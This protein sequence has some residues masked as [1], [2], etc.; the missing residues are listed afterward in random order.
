MPLSRIAG[1]FCLYVLFA[2]IVTFGFFSVAY[3]AGDAADKQ[4]LPFEIRCP[5][6]QKYNPEHDKDPKKPKCIKGENKHLCTCKDITAGDVAVEGICYQAG[7]CTGEIC[8]GSKCRKTEPGQVNAPSE[9]PDT[10]APPPI[11]DTGGLGQP[12]PP[13]TTGGSPGGLGAPPSTGPDNSATNDPNS[14]TPATEPKSIWD[15]AL[16]NFRETGAT[17]LEAGGPQ[18]NSPAAEFNNAFNQIGS[19]PT[20]TNSAQPYNPDGSPNQNYYSGQSSATG[21]NAPSQ[22][23]ES[24]GGSWWDTA[25]QWGSSAWD[26]TKSTVS[27]WF[28]PESVGEPSP[29]LSDTGDVSG[30]APT[31][32]EVDS[33]FNGLEGT[34]PAGSESTPDPNFNG[35]EGAEPVDSQSWWDKYVATPFKDALQSGADFGQKMA[36][37]AFQGGE[38]GGTPTETGTPSDAYNPEP[39]FS[40]EGNV[41][42]KE[43]NAAADAQIEKVAAEYQAAGDL[44][45][46]KYNLHQAENKAIDAANRQTADQLTLE[47]RKEVLDKADAADKAAMEK[48]GGKLVENPPTPDCNEENGCTSYSKQFP[49]EKAK[50]AYE[51]RGTHKALNEAY[52][53]YETARNNY[54][55]SVQNAVDAEKE[56]QQT[57]TDA[58]DAQAAYN[59]ARKDNGYYDYTVPKS[60]T[61]TNPELGKN[62]P[63]AASPDTEEVTFKANSYEQAQQQLQGYIKA[64]QANVLREA[65]I[66]A[67]NQALQDIRNGSGNPSDIPVLQKENADLA[68]ANQLTAQRL[69]DF[70]NGNLD[71]ELTK[72]A[73]PNSPFLDAIKESG[74]DR[75][76]WGSVVQNWKDGNYGTAIKE[77]FENVVGGTLGHIEERFATAFGAPQNP[78]EGVFDPVGAKSDRIAAVLET[79]L[80][81][82]LPAYDLGRAGV[83][84]GRE[85]L[86][87]LSEVTNLGRAGAIGEVS[88]VTGWSRAGAAVDARA[89]EGSVLEGTVTSRFA[90]ESGTPQWTA[91]AGNTGALAAER[92]ALTTTSDGFTS[93]TGQ[94]RATLGSGGELAAAERSAVGDVNTVL[95]EQRSFVGGTTPEL[96]TESFRTISGGTLKEAG[97][98]FK[99]GTG[100]GTDIETQ[101]AIKAA[102]PSAIV[103]SNTGEVVAVRSPG[104][105]FVA[106][107]PKV[108]GTAPSVAERAAIDQYYASR[109]ANNGVASQDAIRA[110]EQNGLRPQPGLKVENSR[111]QANPGAEISRY[112]SNERL[113][114]L[115][116]DGR[117]A[118]YDPS[119]VAGTAEADAAKILDNAA[120]IRNEIISRPSVPE[121]LSPS[122]VPE[123]PGGSGA[124]S[125][126]GKVPLVRQLSYGATAFD[127]SGGAVLA[128]EFRAAT[129]PTFAS[130]IVSV[131]SVSTL[132]G[133]GVFDT[134]AAALRGFSAS[135]PWTSA[136]GHAALAIP[137]SS[138]MA[139]PNGVVSVDPSGAQTWSPAALA[140]VSDPTLVGV[141]ETGTSPIASSPDLASVPAGS[142]P[143]GDITSSVPKGSG[144]VTSAIPQGQVPLPQARPTNAPAP[145]PFQSYPTQKLPN[146][147]G[148]WV[149]SV[150]KQIV[151]GTIF[152][153]AAQAADIRPGT[154]PAAGMASLYKDT[155]N[156]PNEWGAIMVAGKGKAA[157]LP[158]VEGS[159]QGIMYPITQTGIDRVVNQLTPGGKPSDITLDLVFFMHTHPKS[160]SF[161]LFLNGSEKF[162]AQGYGANVSFPPSRED[163]NAMR[164]D[165]FTFP[166]LGFNAENTSY[167]NAA[168]TPRGLFVMRKTIGSDG[169]N[170]PGYNE[171]M[172]Q[173]LN[174]ENELMVAKDDL[175]RGI[176]VLPVDTVKN[177]VQ[178]L[179]R[180]YSDNI[181][182]S[183]GSLERYYTDLA[184]QGIR[185]YVFA[186]EDI[187]ALSEQLRVAGATV[188]SLAQ[189]QSKVTQLANINERLDFDKAGDRYVLATA[190]PNF[191]T[192]T[193]PE[194]QDL[195][196]AY[197]F[198][199]GATMRFIPWEDFN[200]NIAPRLA[201]NPE[202]LDPTY[203]SPY[204]AMPDTVVTEP[205]VPIPR[206]RPVNLGKRADFLSTEF[207]NVVVTQQ[208]SWGDWL[209]SLPSQFQSNPFI[210]SAKAGPLTDSASFT[211][212]QTI[213]SSTYTPGGGGIEGSI[214]A[215]YTNKP[216]GPNEFATLNP[217]VIPPFSV[218]EF[219]G[220]N[221][222]TITL[223]ATD[224]GYY[225]GRTADLQKSQAREI[226]CAENGLC[227]VSYKIVGRPSDAASV[228]SDNLR[229]IRSGTKAADI[230]K[231][232]QEA[233]TMIASARPTEAP[234][235]VTLASAPATPQAQPIAG[236][237]PSQN[238]LAQLKPVVPGDVFSNITGVNPLQKGYELFDAK[239]KSLGVVITSE[240]APTFRTPEQVGGSPSQQVAQNPQTSALPPAA[241][242]QAP[243]TAQYGPFRVSVPAADSPTATHPM[244]VVLAPETTP[245]QSLSE[246]EAR[247]Q[248]VIA[249]AKQAYPN[250]V[251][252]DLAA[253]LAFNGLQNTPAFNILRTNAGLDIL[254]TKNLKPDQ[255][256]SINGYIAMQVAQLQKPAGYPNVAVG[257]KGHP[258]V[259]YP[260][261]SNSPGAYNV[262]NNFLWD[263]I[264]NSPT[265]YARIDSGGDF[266]WKDIA[267][268]LNSGRSLRDEVLNMNPELKASL[269][270]ALKQMIAEGLQPSALAFYRDAVNRPAA[271]GQVV[272]SPRNSQHFAGGVGN[273]ADIGSANV[274]PRADNMTKAERKASDD[275]RDAENEKIWDRLAEIG[276]QYNLRANFISNDPAHVQPAGNEKILAK[277]QQQ[278][279]ADTR[280][281]ASNNTPVITG[282]VPSQTLAVSTPA[283]APKT[284]TVDVPE[285]AKNFPGSSGKVQVSFPNGLNPN[286]PIETY[287]YLPGNDTPIASGFPAKQNQI[288][289]QITAQNAM[290]ISPDTGAIPGNGNLNPEA[291]TSA[292]DAVKK[293][294]G[295]DA[296]KQPIN[297]IAFSGGATPAKQALS[298][299]V[300]NIESITLLDVPNA[301][302]FAKFATDYEKAVFVSYS[303]KGADAGKYEASNKEL[304]KELGV[305]PVADVNQVTSAAI[306][307]PIVVTSARVGVHNALPG[308]GSLAEILNALN[309]K[310]TRA[311]APAPTLA[312]APASPAPVAEVL[313]LPQARPYGA[314]AK[315]WGDFITA[316]AREL[317]A[318]QVQ[319]A[320][321]TRASQEAVAKAKAEADAA[322]KAEK[323][324]YARFDKQM[325]AELIATLNRL[326]AA[327][328]DAAKA[329]AKAQA[330]AEAK[331]RAEAQAAVNA[332]KAE[333]ATIAKANAEAAA[334]EEARLK[335]EA[336]AQKDEAARLQAIADAAAKA[337]RDKVAAETKAQVAALEAERKA[338]AEEMK[339][340]EASKVAVRLP[341]PRPIKAS[342]KISDV[343]SVTV[344]SPKP[345]VARPP[346]VAK[347][348]VKL[349]TKTRPVVDLRSPEQIEK[350]IAALKEK[351]DQAQAQSAE[352]QKLLPAAQAKFA[353][354]NN[355]NTNITDARRSVTTAKSGIAA[356]RAALANMGASDAQKATIANGVAAARGLPEKLAAIPGGAV[357]IEPI[358]SY[359]AQAA[360]LEASPSPGG[361]T[362]TANAGDS[363]V[364]QVST[365]LDKARAANEPLVVAAQGEFLALQRQIA[366]ADGVL[367]QVQSLQAA[368]SAAEK[369][370]AEVALYE[371]EAQ[372]AVAEAKTRIDQIDA[373]VMKKITNDPE[374]GNLL[375]VSK[376]PAPSIVQKSLY[377][378]VTTA[379]SEMFFGKVPDAAPSGPTLTAGTQP[380]IEVVPGV[381]LAAAKPEPVVTPGETSASQSSDA[382][383]SGV[384]TAVPGA[385]VQTPATPAPASP[386]SP[387]QRLISLLN[388]RS[389]V[390]NAAETLA[391]SPS[392]ITSVTPP[393]PLPPMPEPPVEP[394]TLA[395]IPDEIGGFDMNLPKEDAK[396][397]PEQKPAPE[398]SAERPTFADIPDE[399][400]G[401]DVNNPW[402]YGKLSTNEG[403]SNSLLTRARDLLKATCLNGWRGGAICGLIAVAPFEKYITGG[404]G[405][406]STPGAG[407]AAGTTPP[408]G[409]TGV[410]CPTQK[411]GDT[412]S[413]TPCD[414]GAKT[415]PQP[416]PTKP[417]QKPPQGPPSPQVP[418]YVQPQPSVTGFP[419]SQNNRISNFSMYM[420]GNMI[421]QFLNQMFGNNQQT[422]PT[423]PSNVQPSVTP[424]PVVPPISTTTP[425][426]NDLPPVISLKAVP[427][428]ISGVGTSTLSWAVVG[429]SSCEL[430]GFSEMY[431]AT[432]PI[433]TIGT[434]AIQFAT[435]TTFVMRCQSSGGLI[436]AAT[437]TV[438]V[439]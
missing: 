295:I 407:G 335:A 243:V 272:A 432:I 415:P 153:S 198:N 41:L 16:D 339:K 199:G 410:P 389:R 83:S 381:T 264:Y 18:P 70:K 148:N 169:A 309:A 326:A 14:L 188:P 306:E 104:G 25:K 233:Q 265:A 58:S 55:E 395:D 147:W 210:S 304:A 89:F 368:K 92:G 399:L 302:S 289:S 300:L 244:R 439:Q 393:P 358:K 45:D 151:D 422:Q 434:W 347:T 173:R 174:L 127:V 258:I 202:I 396:V 50:K 63:L 423:T 64:Q 193:S 223:V 402:T 130:E 320:A 31:T 149:A 66:A 360:A 192:L 78:Y 318:E 433:E 310:S 162:P 405:V 229:F 431:S 46:A 205:G 48:Y 228:V 67:N 345:N 275:A 240:G 185:D 235:G 279:A 121:I 270:G 212:G 255:V 392:P 136:Y 182:R 106:V 364:A 56:Y 225:P 429:A 237:A 386:T 291:L 251:N 110:L 307:E 194:Y 328:A 424:K 280:L 165:R 398:K 384:T 178:S 32:P 355:L 421:G 105:D 213:T 168:L 324:A 316:R 312:A 385:V 99:Y 139:T 276:S 330:A 401:F 133:E 377:E 108:A 44:A 35:I 327:D 20:E 114:S 391:P 93:M 47:A 419:T 282:A 161:D 29:S 369:A 349:P 271:T 287:L 116:S 314:D 196:Y 180:N 438:V 129:T 420:I 54:I 334:K 61:A 425:S 294:T 338:L 428:I 406:P 150:Q 91:G 141:F 353:A 366:A 97:L 283:P 112:G 11:D 359:L 371:A 8:D 394:P 134:S 138:M 329:V 95:R 236:Q 296:A 414:S 84:L 81:V 413:A 34:P 351:A 417:A 4:C 77:G 418:P 348:A 176:R 354:A 273:A 337:A 336:K 181:A 277:L 378:E 71:A 278:I 412:L 382:A 404:A 52:K 17:G 379:L 372:R 28:S 115:Q 160:S 238:F 365:F 43:Q 204:T 224:K 123:I 313:P 257:A 126:L 38:G 142:S 343:A 341:S 252:K 322:V 427:A 215:T 57:K 380:Q 113:A 239:G 72:A 144:G 74:R 137:A 65:Q 109:A 298:S 120:T 357:Y 321:E 40:P 269:Y 299:G 411:L 197:I 333:E 397:P 184:G 256:R 186:G 111:A 375:A 96:R 370:A 285:L 98:E 30:V 62:S 59:Q 435:S 170:V 3:A 217:R 241:Q 367:K 7:V 15:R 331:A 231:V 155:L 261:S 12:Q 177:I 211:K 190:D 206:E 342:P 374:F 288:N 201:T 157:W 254:G 403:A 214:L 286:A 390:P 36:D 259:S 344:K 80:N 373:E 262:V 387:W 267:A 437:T 33:T 23:T 319:I 53:N 27:G 122:L 117:Y 284:Q 166:A 119:R 118:L 281:A 246:A 143:T 249:A 292:L 107:N 317:R 156:S 436:G 242:Q 85:A 90:Y 356:L 325:A 102:Q 208:R 10:T 101:A 159:A 409:G 191:N 140:S 408:G 22:T 146:T 42:S 363:L 250:I 152:S 183:I 219:T 145:Q 207:S 268:A 203:K 2:I 218:V 248:N 125:G 416:D 82:G 164:A 79:G 388:F 352:A 6:G 172:S 216:V 88:E 297:L 158:A 24:Q 200:T 253:Q 245:P 230:Q 179:P 346:V 103:R 69:A 426:T 222:K 187:T 21:F 128:N 135:S 362:A 1:L 263:K 303:T 76:D 26:T 308:D 175:E 305:T 290:V 332:A 132:A 60:Y 49:D 87:G 86:G 232:M 5:C 315:A 124:L 226:G 383:P 234:S 163:V 209:A 131:R 340:A 247:A 73:E 100:V 171:L 301:V 94:A 9:T 221:G 227:Q 154:T 13:Q 260:A 350:E 75:T 311:P 361:V 19:L 68:A 400:G 37:A 293:A 189:I 430:T 274:V 51:D 195:V 167:I 39:A 266:T 220:P 323:D 376:P